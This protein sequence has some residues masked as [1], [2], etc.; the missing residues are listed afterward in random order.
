MKR[1]LILFLAA[2]ALPSLAGDL[3]NADFDKE[4]IMRKKDKFEQLSIQNEF[5]FNCGSFGMHMKKCFVEF[6][7]G[8]MIVDGSTGIIPSQIKHIYEQPKSAG[9]YLYLIYEESQGKL[10]HAGFGHLGYIEGSSFYKRFL[11]WLN[12]N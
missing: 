12:E 3:G 8:R 7:D 9:L 6:K 5:E 10:S 11:D 2:I 4:R 1:L